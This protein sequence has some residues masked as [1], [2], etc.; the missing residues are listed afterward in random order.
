MESDTTEVPCNVFCLGGPQPGSDTFIN[1][2][3]VLF[4]PKAELTVND[5]FRA[6]CLGTSHAR[7]GEGTLDGFMTIL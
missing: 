5:L 7:G 4:P 1:Y 6:T 3:L 2:S